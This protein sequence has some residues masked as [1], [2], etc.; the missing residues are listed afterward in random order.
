MILK[1][2]NVNKFIHTCPCHRFGKQL[3][4]S[5]FKR[6]RNNKRRT[7]KL[8]ILIP[9]DAELADSMDK[10]TEV[11]FS[12]LIEIKNVNDTLHPTIT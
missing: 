11:N 3:E 8:N 7:T 10:L 1:C 9:L 5:N 12:I 4:K 2:E 6:G